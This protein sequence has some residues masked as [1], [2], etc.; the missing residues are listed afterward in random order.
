MEHVHHYDST[1][2]R[3]LF[4]A[5]FFWL[6]KDKQCGR[7]MFFFMRKHRHV[8]QSFNIVPTWERPGS[9]GDFCNLKALT[10]FLTLWLL[11]LQLIPGNFHTVL[12]SFYY[13][14]HIF[15]LSNSV[16]WLVFTFFYCV[17]DD[18]LIQFQK[19]PNE[20]TLSNQ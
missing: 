7:Q 13:P 11:T 19:Y 15:L 18:F 9:I 1:S 10:G 8:Y 6:N 5:F 16:C 3:W 2:K 4:T 14:F 20:F 12:I 17:F